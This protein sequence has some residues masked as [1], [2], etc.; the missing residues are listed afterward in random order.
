MAM[1]A[2][3]TPV[4]FSVSAQEEAPSLAIEEII[5]TARKKGRVYSRCAYGCYSYYRS[6]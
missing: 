6:T 2:I 3:V 5:V 4:S 1:F